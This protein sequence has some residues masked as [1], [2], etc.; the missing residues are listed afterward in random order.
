MWRGHLI[1]RVENLRERSV[2]TIGP[3]RCT[4]RSIDELS[5]DAQAVTRLAHAAFEHVAHPSS[6]PLA[7]RPLARAKHAS[8][9][10]GRSEER[11]RSGD[12]EGAT[13]AAMSA[14]NGRAGPAA[15]DVRP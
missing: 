7:S 11:G 10:S 4:G 3:K 15:R 5:R 6:R 2:E 13:R 1:L 8:L 9:P 14:S 12:V